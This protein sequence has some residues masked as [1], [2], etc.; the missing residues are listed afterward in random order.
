MGQPILYF[1]LSLFAV[2]PLQI[3]PVFAVQEPVQDGVGER[4]GA[5]VVMPVFGSGFCPGA[6]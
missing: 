4:G 6:L 2:I 1:V 5:N 3:E